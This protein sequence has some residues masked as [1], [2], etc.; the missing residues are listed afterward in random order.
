[1]MVAANSVTAEYLEGKKFPSL[2][3]VVRTPKR[4]ERI[5]EIARQHG[6][7]LPATPD[8]RALNEFLNQQQAA[9]PLRF[10]DLSLAVIK[11]LGP[12]EYVAEMP[13]ETDPPGHF[14]LA[15][16]HYSH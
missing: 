3:R 8:S 15:V 11:L 14:A 6:C 10:P 13:G 4:W 1:F 16:E 2:R 9:G 5:V 12:G 7:T